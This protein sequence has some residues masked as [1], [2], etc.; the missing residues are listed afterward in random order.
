[1]EDESVKLPPSSVVRLSIT[2]LP[3]PLPL[4]YVSSD[5]AAPDFP[6]SSGQDVQEEPAHQQA[7]HADGRLRRVCD[8]ASAA[9][10]GEAQVSVQGAETRADARRRYAG[11]ITVSLWLRPSIFQEGFIP[12]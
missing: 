9:R 2:S 8:P 10:A 3:S 6:R 7:A 4:N 5:A 11:K 1:M 12:Y